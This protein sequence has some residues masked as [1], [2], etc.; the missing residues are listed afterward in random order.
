MVHRSGQADS[1]TDLESQ[2]P[3]LLP[4]AVAWAEREER[5][6]LATGACL[7]EAEHALARFLGVAHPERVRIRLVDTMPSPSDPML[8]AAI[9]QTAMLGPDTRGLTLGH[10]IFVQRE[11]Q[12]WRLLSH[13]LRHVY[14]YEQAG[15][16][17]EFLAVYLRQMLEYGYRDAPLEVDARA[18]ERMDA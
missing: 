11:A 9:R 5:Q 8:Q 14:Q 3:L 15:S 12:S 4:R 17:A 6:V 1:V 7:T 18:H 2:L 16:I 10:A 13:E